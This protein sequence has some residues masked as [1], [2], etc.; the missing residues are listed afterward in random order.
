MGEQELSEGL[1][2][3][4]PTFSGLFHTA[5]FKSLLYKAKVT[6]NMGV[7]EAP[8]GAALGLDSTERLFSELVPER[9]SLHLL[10]YSWT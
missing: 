1:V 9:R 6:A 2:P 7:S 4:R 3:N 8:A 10:S 5:L